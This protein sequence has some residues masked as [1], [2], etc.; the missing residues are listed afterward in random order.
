MDTARWLKTLRR[1][2]SDVDTAAARRE[3]LELL[4]TADDVRWE[5]EARAVAGFDSFSVGLDSTDTVTYGPVG[6]TDNQQ[7]ILLFGAATALLEE[8]YT[9][10]LDRGELGISWKSG[11]EEESSISA[12]KAYRDRIDDIRKTT[13]E[14][15]ITYQRFTA[16][17]RPQ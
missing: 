17:G 14:L 12:Q 3:D 15:L 9:G 11:L 6:A 13:N 1:K 10:R 2:L 8:T 7:L 4:E 16:N 5:L